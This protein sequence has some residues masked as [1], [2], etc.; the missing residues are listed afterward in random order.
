MCLPACLV[1]LTR[2]LVAL[3]VAGR[4]VQIYRTIAGC[5]INTTSHIEGHHSSLKVGT[6]KC[7]LSECNELDIGHVTNM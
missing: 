2:A 4:I 3:L 5:T 6:F 7:L 1:D